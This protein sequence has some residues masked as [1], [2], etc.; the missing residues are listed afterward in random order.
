MAT[1]P[2]GTI[3]SAP[4]TVHQSFLSPIF[5]NLYLSSQLH[6]DDLCTFHTQ[7]S[8]FLCHDRQELYITSPLEFKSRPN[9]SFVQYNSTLQHRSV[10]T[11]GDAHNIK[12]IPTK[13]HTIRL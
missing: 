10:I 8:E 13:T 3:L 1:T 9:L 5:F 7:I 11:S 12:Q 2:D 4:K 6:S